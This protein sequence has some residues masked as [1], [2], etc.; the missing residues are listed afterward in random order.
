MPFCTITAIYILLRFTAPQQVNRGMQM[1][2]AGC[3][4]NQSLEVLQV[5]FADTWIQNV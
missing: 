2:T 5:M 3:A 1:K 4:R